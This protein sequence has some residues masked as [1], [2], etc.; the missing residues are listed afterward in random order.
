[1]RCNSQDKTLQGSDVSLDLKGRRFFRT[2]EVRYDNKE[3]GDRKD[4]CKHMYM[5]MW[6]IT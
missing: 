5:Y 1:M 3:A 4:I 2:F 6:M